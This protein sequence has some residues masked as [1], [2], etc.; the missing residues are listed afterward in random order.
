MADRVHEMSFPQAG[1][2]VYEKR[3]VSAGGSMSYSH[4]SRVSQLAIGAYNEIFE[5]I[6]TIERCLSRVIAYG[7]DA[8]H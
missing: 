7:S 4:G 5:G 3:I 2:A 8:P 6:A 1:V